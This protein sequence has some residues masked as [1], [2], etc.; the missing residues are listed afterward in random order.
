MSTVRFNS[1]SDYL[2]G[3]F[4][5]K[6]Y[7]ISLDIGATCPNRDG[8]LD[9]RGCIF[10]SSGSS[11]FAE[12]CGDVAAAVEKARMQVA[13]KTTAGK[14]IAYFGSYS[15]TYLPAVRLRDILFQTVS[16]PE[17]SAVSVGT[18]PD[19]LPDDILDVLKET[20]SVKP[21]FV[22]LGL[23]TSNE[24]TAEYIRRRYPNSV[25][26]DAVSRLRSAGINVVTHMII[27]LPGETRKDALETVRFAASNGTDGIKF[28]VLQILRGTDLEK[29]FLSGKISALGI[30]EYTDILLD[31]IEHLPANITIHRL[32]GDPPRDL[33]V[34]PIWCC[35]KKR[36]LNTIRREMEKRDIYQG[37]KAPAV[38]AGKKQN[39]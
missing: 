34:A 22:E 2:I 15:S 31:C 14:F 12:K 18:R 32:T 9:T 1:L 13:K 11:H 39:G 27:G 10:C 33:I 25:Y 35:D 7:R 26:S 29:E 36:T 38:H 16:L 30:G 37:K 21:V 5:E 8:T 28:H 3:R 4:G 23:Q 17:I 20:A 6:V 24:K 19:C